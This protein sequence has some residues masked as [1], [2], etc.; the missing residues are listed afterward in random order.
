MEPE[1]I[2]VGMEVWTA[3]VSDQSSAN[4][5]PFHVIGDGKV[6]AVDDGLR[7]PEAVLKRQCGIISCVPCREIFESEANA[8]EHVVTTLRRMAAATF[9]AANEVESRGAASAVSVT[10]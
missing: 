8:C 5:V 6:L 2:S 9:D 10:K 4:G 7:G 3:Y 1:N